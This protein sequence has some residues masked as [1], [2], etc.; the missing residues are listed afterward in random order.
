[1][2][3]AKL[4]NRQ[5]LRRTLHAEQM[6]DKWESR[7]DRYGFDFDNPE[8]QDALHLCMMWGRLA[9]RLHDEEDRRGVEYGEFCKQTGWPRD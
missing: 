5:L 8:R 4:T 6:E 1:M 7:L 2:N 9:W 3:L